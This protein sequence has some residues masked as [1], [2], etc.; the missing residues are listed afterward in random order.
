MVGV[1][2]LSLSL[3]LIHILLECGGEAKL[4]TYHTKLMQTDWKCKEDISI[5]LKGL[6]MDVVW[7]NIIV[8]IGG[9]TIEQ[10]NTL[11]EQIAFCLLYTSY[12]LSGS[13][14]MISASDASMRLVISFLAVKDLPEPDTPRMNELPFRSFLLSAIIMFFEMTF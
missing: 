5:E 2:S 6:N 8:Q 4:A 12:S 7:E 1:S 3:S 13:M 9:I 11:D 10:G 14:I